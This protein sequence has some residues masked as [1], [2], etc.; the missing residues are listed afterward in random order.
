M[1]PYQYKT[2]YLSIGLF[3]SPENGALK[4]QDKIEEFVQKGWELFAYHPIQTMFA[5]KWNILIFRK[6]TEQT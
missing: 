2:V 3:G 5:W 6:P 1:G 4:I